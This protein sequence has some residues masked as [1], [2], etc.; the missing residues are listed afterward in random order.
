M[1]KGVPWK[2]AEWA[3]AEQIRQVLHSQF[4]Y[5][6]VLD[7]YYPW[8]VTL[9]AKALQTA[10]ATVWDEFKAAVTTV[11][12]QLAVLEEELA[13]GSATLTEAE[14][15]RLTA[16]ITDRKRYLAIRITF[17][18]VCRLF[19]TDAHLFQVLASKAGAALRDCLL[20]IPKQLV[21]LVALLR[22]L[23]LTLPL[24]AVPAS[25]RS[26]VQAGKT[27]T[28]TTGK[29]GRVTVSLGKYIHARVQDHV[30]SR[31]TDLYPADPFPF[32]TLRVR[33]QGVFGAILARACLTVVSRRE[34]RSVSEIAEVLTPE[35]VLSAPFRAGRDGKPTGPA[36]EPWDRQVFPIELVTNTHLPP[37]YRSAGKP[38]EVQFGYEALSDAWHRD[39]H[40][41]LFLSLPATLVSAIWTDPKAF[42]LQSYLTAHGLTKSENQAVYTFLEEEVFSQA[43]LKTHKERYGLP[44]AGLPME[45]PLST[46]SKRVEG[47]WRNRRVYAYLTH[48]RVRLAHLRVL[49]PKPGS[50]KVRLNL[51]FAAPTEVALA[52]FAPSTNFMAAV[53]RKRGQTTDPVETPFDPAAYAT[54]YAWDPTGPVIGVDINR[55]SRYLIACG[56]PTKVIP[57]EHHHLAEVQKLVRK[58]RRVNYAKLWATLTQTPDLQEQ[59]E[60]AQKFA[61]SPAGR[62]LNPLF[63]DW[64]PASLKAIT[65]S[66][67]AWQVLRQG[68][69]AATEPGMAKE[70]AHQVLERATWGS[71]YDR[72]DDATQLLVF[73]LE[74][75]EARQPAAAEALQ[76]LKQ[77]RRTCR[78]GLYEEIRRAQRR[79]ALL[80]KLLADHGVWDRAKRGNR[81]AIRLVYQY[82]Y[83]RRDVRRALASKPLPRVEELRDR[84]TRRRNRLRNELTLLHRRKAALKAALDREVEL[85]LSRLLL[86]TH[87]RALA[88]EDLTV[89]TRGARGQL[90]K[91]VTDMAKRPEVTIRVSQRV[92]T[93]HTMGLHRRLLLPR[94]VVHPAGT[95]QMCAD[96]PDEAVRKVPGIYDWQY[97]AAGAHY[98]PRH[99]NS[100]RL[101][102]QRAVHLIPTASTLAVG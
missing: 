21:G 17:E 86:Q 57:L 102:A 70:T 19:A 72:L 10:A 6:A 71:D 45:V 20:P 59:W 82:Y 83:R 8:R 85:T 43:A 46:P 93:Y 41:R 29:G 2:T 24:N 62:A 37:L 44:A 65:E 42:G 56:T 80:D 87:G 30:H 92:G 1:P 11:Q 53:P 25:L 84:L 94:L 40:A 76:Q 89:S 54:K 55:P 60:A 63:A 75:E 28:P 16:K 4:D 96:H 49:P 99:G 64:L 91:Y 77:L 38:A 34:K 14:K 18:E 88:V 79:L 7:K 23:P 5:T 33:L 58:L 47:K 27:Q 26:E 98:V 101:I 32:K 3:A 90:A 66:V 95:S 36:R 51:V 78:E 15:S 68:K 39:P 31:W 22:K 61:Q 9:T 67:A 97:C 100:A 50:W 12:E 48:P 81:A 13:A 52:L 35:H 69:K 74:R 73:Y